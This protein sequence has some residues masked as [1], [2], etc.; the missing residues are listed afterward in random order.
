MAI[1]IDRIGDSRDQ[2]GESPVWSTRE[3]A[4]YWV[5]SLAG[6]LHRLQWGSGRRE[7]WAVPAPVGSFGL[8]RDGGV[9]LALADGFHRYDPATRAT[10][11]LAKSPV[12]HPDVRLNDGKVDRQ[13]RFLAGSMHMNLAPGA[14]SRGALYRLEA[15]GGVT[16]LAEDIVTANGPCFSPDG[17]TLFLADSPRRVIWRLD[18]RDGQARG[19]APFIDLAALDSAPDGATVDAAGHLW[20]AL[21]RSGEIGRFDAIGRLVQRIA[22]P[23]RHPT[24]VNFGGPG[25]DVLFVTSISASHRLQDPA[26]EAGGVFAIT[27]LDA[28][29][30]AEPLISR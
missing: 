16:T 4:L 12:Q 6:R 29:G 14:A 8:C 23:V 28:Q 9:V 2:L 10:T 17:A 21:V 13:G 5:D 24:S 15:D 7:D 3:Q 19:R 25:L 18:Y 1:A 22:M 27:G 11:L 30:I 26:P 20:V